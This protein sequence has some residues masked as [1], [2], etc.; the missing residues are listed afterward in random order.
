[1]TF[2]SI[3]GNDPV[4]HLLKS[5]I[6]KNA[7]PN[8]LLFHGM[9]GI[10]KSLFAEAVAKVLLDPHSNSSKRIKEGNHP[11]LHVYLPEGKSN[12]HSIAS[13][14]AFSDEVFS[15]P[16]ESKRKVFIIHDAER[17]L[18]AAANAL[19]KTLEEPL[20]DTTIILI[21]S[22]PGSLL[23]TIL[24]RSAKFSFAPLSE[25]EIEAY[26]IQNGI[27]QAKGLARLSFGSLG[28]ALFLAKDPTF[29]E[30]RE[31]LLDLLMKRGIHSHADLWQKCEKLQSYYEE[32]SLEEEPFDLIFS[33]ILLWYRDLEMKD[34]PGFS[35][36]FPE[37]AEHTFRE[38]RFSKIQE[39]LEKAK[40]AS[41][42]GIKLS[43]C[44][45]YFFLTL[46]T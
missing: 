39:T 11:D 5:A 16:F 19:L 6:Q 14:R 7:L 2:E 3:L 43:V 40:T 24:S 36:H 20:L 28:N 32:K 9:Q 33:Q 10:G 17:M 46:L 4:K 34:V 22:Q 35:P 12:L 26:L 21:S 8:T 45:E 41:Q 31:L 30:K 42:R 44:L 27:L 15:S 18:P 29:S 37:S 38:F 23:P 1:M 25:K 13:M